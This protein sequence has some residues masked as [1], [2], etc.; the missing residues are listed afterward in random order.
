M[1]CPFL[2]LKAQ[3][4]AQAIASAPHAQ[5]QQSSA[6][7]QS[8]S[9]TAKLLKPA[10]VSD[11]SVSGLPR[12][13][14]INPE[15]LYGAK[16]SSK[17]SVESLIAQHRAKAPIATSVASGGMNM[18]G[19]VG[20]S[21]AGNL[22]RWQQQ[23][24][25]KASQPQA[26]VEILM[27]G[28]QNVYSELMAAAART[29]AAAGG[30]GGGNLR[31]PP[32]PYPQKSGA[33]NQAQQAAVMAAAAASSP[34]LQHTLN[35]GSQMAAAMAAAARNSSAAAAMAGSR[36]GNNHADQAAANLSLT[37]LLDNS[38]VSFTKMKSRLWTRS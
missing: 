3:V 38:R 2:R 27:D 11:R 1:S 33:V 24:Q 14:T 15:M 19:T 7:T 37:S 36:G 34:H 8:T 18:A 30:A 28:G 10:G 6:Q 21:N 13:M 17:V 32:P 35:I 20:N 29:A 23:S 5:Q 4:Q 26:D 22:R 25:G 12:A 31:G 16:A 9:V